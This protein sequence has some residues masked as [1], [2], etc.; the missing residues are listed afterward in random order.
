MPNGFSHKLILIKNDL[1]VTQPRSLTK[2]EEE[3]E[4]ENI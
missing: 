1:S 3:E 4:N 2:K